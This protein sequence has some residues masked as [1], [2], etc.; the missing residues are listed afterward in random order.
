MPQAALKELI[1]GI[2]L[3]S[4]HTVDIAG[5]DP[6]LPVR[7]RVAAAASAALGALGVAAANLSGISQRVSVNARAAAVSLRAAHYLRINRE[8]LPP[9]WDPMSGFYPVRDGWISIHCNFPNH[10]D[11][12][13]TVLQVSPDRARAEEASR[14]SRSRASAKRRLIRRRR[15][16]VRSS[17]CACST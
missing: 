3:G 1:E 6:V 13:T 7:Y 12:A 15:G 8:P 16:R 9:V 14:C 5:D 4:E 11:A 2:G 10:R 17:A